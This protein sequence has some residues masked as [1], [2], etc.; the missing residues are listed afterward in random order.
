VNID[1]LR[2]ETA[3]SSSSAAVTVGKWITHELFL[4]W[5]QRLEPRP[6]ENTGQA[7]IEYWLQRRLAI[8]G[9]IGDRGYNGADLLWRRRW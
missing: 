9:T 6:D 1:V 5:T 7:E 8:T 4:A 2:Y 3:T